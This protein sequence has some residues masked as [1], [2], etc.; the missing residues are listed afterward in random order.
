MNN[1]QLFKES[2]KLV[3]KY[4]VWSACT[5]KN[6]NK[7][8]IFIFVSRRSGGTWLSEII[9]RQ[10]GIRQISEPFGLNHLPYPLV[11]EMPIQ[12]HN[13]LIYL[14]SEDLETM[15]EYFKTILDGNLILNSEWNVF[16]NKFNLTANR[17][18]IKIPNALAMLPWFIDIYN[19]K[20]IYHIRHPIGQAISCIKNKYKNTSLV[21]LHNDWFRENNLSKEMIQTGERIM[22][23]GSRLEKHVLNWALENLVPLQMDLKGNERVL[24]TSYENLVINLSESLQNIHSFCDVDFSKKIDK[25]KKPSR[26]TL[27]DGEER[28]KKAENVAYHWKNKIAKKDE[29]RCMDIL[30][31]FNIQIY[32]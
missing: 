10:E 14:D 15:R 19:A 21:Y 12:E 27:S 32:A 20:F 6:E 4:F 8:N 24:L 5:Y 29:I 3:A 11:Q 2:L 16:S 23:K 13:Q 1:L 28:I 17:L 25:Y 18:V 9:A 26:T 31:C 22:E 30:R 7:Q